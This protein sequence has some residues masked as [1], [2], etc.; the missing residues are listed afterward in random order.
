ME[1]SSSKVNLLKLS[2]GQDLVYAISN[3]RIKT[4]KSILHPYAIKSL[5]NSTKLITNDQLEYGVSASIVE[6][7]ATENAF[8]VLENQLDNSVFFEWC[9]KGDI[10]DDCP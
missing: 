2:I 5:T 6:E 9:I 8:R 7:L 10:Y 1:N 4:P 3:G